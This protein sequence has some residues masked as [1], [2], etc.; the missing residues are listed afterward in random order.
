[1]SHSLDRVRGH[2]YPRL[3]VSAADHS[4]RASNI[5]L[6]ML[7][8]MLAVLMVAYVITLAAL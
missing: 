2:V 6:G 8:V 4:L 5:V 1:M 7:G 3:N